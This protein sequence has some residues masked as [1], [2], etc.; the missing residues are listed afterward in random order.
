[1]SAPASKPHSDAVVS[2]LTAASVAVGRGKQ[3]DGS[4]WQ[5]TP[6]NSTFNAYAVFYPFTGQEEPT[7]LAMPN[8]SL[9]FQFQLTCVGAVQGQVEAL[10]D[11]VRAALVGATPAVTG[12]VA[13]P[14]YR[15]ELDQTVTRDDAAT[16]PVHYGVARFH[17]RSDPPD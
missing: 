8:A 2:L 9:D 10:M 4:G 3:P 1:M 13:F 14:I 7:A 5:G 11:G 17:F 6:G 12:R 15:V 16:P